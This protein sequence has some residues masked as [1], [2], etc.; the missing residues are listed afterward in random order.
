MKPIGRKMEAHNWLRNGYRFES[1]REAI[2]NFFWCQKGSKKG[3]ELHLTLH[4]LETAACTKTHKHHRIFNHFEG[5]SVGLLDR[6]SIEKEAKTKSKQDL[7]GWLIFCR[8]LTDLGSPLGAESDQ[9]SVKNEVGKPCEKRSNQ[10]SQ[11]NTKEMLW[12]SAAPGVE[13][14][15]KG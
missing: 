2:F 9:K 6:K 3:K 8:I 1:L 10:S 13:A 12:G 4:N 5:S 14:L 7:H 15:G 11:G